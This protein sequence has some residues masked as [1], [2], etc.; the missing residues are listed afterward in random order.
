M[1][2]LQTVVRGGGAETHAQFRESFQSLGCQPWCHLGHERR[3]STVVDEVDIFNFGLDCGPDN[4]GAIKRLPQRLGIA[5]RFVST[6]C[7]AIFIRRSEF[8]EAT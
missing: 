5:R 3:D 8:S 4:Q 1:A 7:G 6:L 2:N